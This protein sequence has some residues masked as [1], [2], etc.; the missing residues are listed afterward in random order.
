M[1]VNLNQAQFV[2]SAARPGDFPRE[3][4]SQVVFDVRSNVVKS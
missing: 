4:L 3:R 1:K 2:R